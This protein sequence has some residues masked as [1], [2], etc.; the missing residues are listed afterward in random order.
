MR[1]GYTAICLALLTLCFG[2][3]IGCNNAKP[4]DT[5]KAAAND[6]SPER[7]EAE[8]ARDA[9]RQF[10]EACRTGDG[11]KAE[12]MYTALARQKLAAE[13]PDVHPQPPASDTARFDVGEPQFLAE[14]GA[15][16]P[17]TWTDLDN[18]DLDNKEGKTRT[19]ELT[20]MIRKEPEGWRIAGLAF[21]VFVGEDPVLFDFEN[22]KETVQKLD[23]L[24]AEIERRKGK[25]GQLAQRDNV[26]EDKQATIAAAQQQSVEAQQYRENDTIQ[27]SYKPPETAPEKAEKSSPS[28][29]R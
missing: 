5:A 3:A 2:A 1:Y 15:R 18:T 19:D 4:E 29:R 21:D 10:L 13:M 7:S 25:S 6:T 17:C 14:D 24:K 22:P 9:A 12:A 11:E 26:T 27:N 20:V 16:V 8:L 23:L 28:L